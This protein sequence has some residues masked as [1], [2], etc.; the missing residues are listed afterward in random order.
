MSQTGKKAD[1]YVVIHGPY[2]G[3]AYSEIFQSLLPIKGQIKE[4]IVSSYV[5]QKVETEQEIA[6]YY[7]QFSLRTV[8]SKD[9]LNP[10]YFNLNRQV[11]T[12]RAALE[13]VDDESALVIKL[14]NDQWFAGKK[15][16]KQ[17]EKYYFA[18]KSKKI[19]STNCFTRKDRL[20]HPSDMFLC[21]P[22]EEMKTYYSLPLQKESHVNIQLQ[23]LKRLRYT[24]DEFKLF[25]VSPE[26]ELFKHYL[27]CKNWRLL[28]TE[29]DS[30][31]ALKQYAH[32]IN[33]WDIDLRWNKKRNACLPAKTIILPYSFTME[34]FAGAPKEEAICYARHNFEGKKTL[35]DSYYLFASKLVYSIQ[36]NRI[37]RW[38]VKLKNRVPKIIKNAVRDTRIGKFFKKASEG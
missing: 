24:N 15:L 25:L 35:R 38:L 30:F 22:I 20:Y 26:S 10:G 31:Q 4:V 3:N 33:T 12:V 27:Q 16:L 9:T 28:F 29:D 32:I 21:G 7:S 11:L 34:P 23:M 13:M 6:A 5:G 1:I 18:G 2:K 36:Y 37:H 19:L 8:Y 17:L 14:R